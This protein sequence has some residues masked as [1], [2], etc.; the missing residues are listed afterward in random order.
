MHQES[1]GGLLGHP[2]NPIQRD[3]YPDLILGRS[4]VGVDLSWCSSLKGAFLDLHQVHHGSPLN[5]TMKA[6]I[7]V[8]IAYKR[9]FVEERKRR[10]CRVI[11]WMRLS[12]MVPS[13]T[14]RASKDHPDV[15]RSKKKT[16]QDFRLEKSNEEDL[17]YPQWNP[18]L[19]QS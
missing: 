16:V 2:E 18:P 10:L 5:P 7:M 19:C 9:D 1:F 15:E 14:R 4:R 8:R 13:F 11:S 6:S 12:R 3:Y 17:R